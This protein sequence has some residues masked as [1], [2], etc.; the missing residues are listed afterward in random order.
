MV[1]ERPKG[2]D[3]P[4][5]RRL[6]RA[7]SKAN[8]AVYR[9]SR[10]RVGARFRLGAGFRRPVPVCL[11][12]TTGRKTGRART[13]PLLFLADGDRVVLVAS[14]GGLPTDPLWFRNLVAEPAVTVQIGGSV[15]AMR[16]RVADP[17][18]RVELW[19]RLTALYTDFDDYA[20]W[21]E[22]VIP[23]VICDPV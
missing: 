14:Q 2:L 9:A 4:G 21:T 3:S 13:C 16:A 18:E 19:P 23:V 5:T 10:G 12:T 8:V 6:I 20:A 15:R 7:L 1:K 22:R 11:L 17:A